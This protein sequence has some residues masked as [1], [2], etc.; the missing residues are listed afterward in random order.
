MTCPL[1]GRTDGELLFVEKLNI[2]FCPE[3]KKK[4]EFEH[5][6]KGKFKVIKCRSCKQ[7]KTIEWIPYKKS[8]R[9]RGHHNRRKLAEN[10]SLLTKFYPP[11]GKK[12]A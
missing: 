7:V 6:V 11:S 12:E 8:G 4:I 9:K 5:Q 10:Q 3:C 2:Y 1:C